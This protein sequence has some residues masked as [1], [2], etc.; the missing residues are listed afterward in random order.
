MN[1]RLS[2]RLRPSSALAWLLTAA[3]T[4][5]AAAVWL[6]PFAAEW[7]L[8]ASLILGGALARDLRRHAWHTAA[9]AVVALDVREDCS[10]TVYSREGGSHEY[11]VAR[12]TFV[13]PFLTVLG[14][15]GEV[16]P[17]AR[18]V[19][20]VPGSL[21]EDSFRRLRVW[22]LC[23]CNGRSAEPRATAV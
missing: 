18:F 2:L 8:A 14:L 21:D 3:Y 13:A 7:S 11:Q 19:L 12:G 5:A 20:I 1:G 23:R 6:A 17:R 4:L 15:K 10:V 22:L 9:A 16:R